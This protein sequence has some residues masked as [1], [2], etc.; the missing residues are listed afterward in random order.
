MCGMSVILV[1]FNLQCVQ[2]ST[3]PEGR[4]QAPGRGVGRSF[5]C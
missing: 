4:S 1:I 3:C 2:A 5:V